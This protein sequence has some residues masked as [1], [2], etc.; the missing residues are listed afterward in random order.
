[1]TGLEKAVS[2]G[3]MLLPGPRS[4]GRVKRQLAVPLGKQTVLAAGRALEIALPVSWE[5]GFYN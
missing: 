2:P 3:Q 1:M 4:A 5:C